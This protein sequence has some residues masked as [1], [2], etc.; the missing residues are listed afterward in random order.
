MVSVTN[1]VHTNAVYVFFQ[2]ATVNLN[3]FESCIRICDL[4]LKYLSQGVSEPAYL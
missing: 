4:P 2:P 1:V 3:V